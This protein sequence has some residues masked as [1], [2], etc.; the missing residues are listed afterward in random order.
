M[1]CGTPDIDIRLLKEKTV[2]HGEIRKLIDISD[3]F[4]RSLKISIPI[5]ARHFCSLY[6][7][8]QGCL[9]QRLALERFLQDHGCPYMLL[10]IELPRYTSKETLRRKLAKT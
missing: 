2:Y 6:G 9:R 8:V 5:I 4:G 7:V 10:P 3:S 1:V